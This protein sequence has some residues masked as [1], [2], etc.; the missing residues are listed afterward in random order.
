MTIQSVS[1]LSA[2]IGDILDDAGVD[3]VVLETKDQGRYVVI[4]LDDD[5][6]DYLVARSPKFIESCKRIRE[7]MRSGQFHSHEDVKKLLEAQ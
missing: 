3:G 6:L 7:R 2:A 5:L 1:D 4:P